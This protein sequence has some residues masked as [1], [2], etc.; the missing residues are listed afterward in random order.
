M[1]DAAGADVP[2]PR[3]K[4][5]GEYGQWRHLVTDEQEWLARPASWGIEYLPAEQQ[6][7]KRELYE[8]HYYGR[9]VSMMSCPICGPLVAG[10]FTE[11]GFQPPS[12]IPTTRD[13]FSEWYAARHPAGQCGGWSAL[14]CMWLHERGAITWTE[15]YN[16]FFS[17]AFGLLHDRAGE[18]LRAGREWERQLSPELIGPNPFRP[19]TFSP[20][21]RTSTAVAIA[22]QMYE[23]RDFSAMPILADALQDAGCEHADVLDHCRGPGPHVRGC[24]VCDLVL[25]K[26]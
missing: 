26:E 11:V 16:Q 1:S 7:R 13:A 19:V 20:E 25:G 14:R 4:E 2:P 21:W 15:M 18:A 22:R 23:G 3:Y 5:A 8:H 9:L 6:G 24:W 10:A 12:G 17:A